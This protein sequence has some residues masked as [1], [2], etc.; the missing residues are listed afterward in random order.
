ML[1]YKD[2]EK[3]VY[4]WLMPK[5]NT[6]GTFTFSLTQNGTKGAELDYFIGTEKSNYI[7]N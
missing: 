3:Q 4:D 1:S 5:Q 6:E 7:A 2:Y